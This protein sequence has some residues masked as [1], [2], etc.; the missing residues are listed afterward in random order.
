MS[1]SAQHQFSIVPEVTYGTTPANPVFKKK[2]ISG[3][4]LGLTKGRIESKAIRPDRQVDDVRHG[5]RLIGGEITTELQY[6]GFDDLIEAVFCGTWTLDVLVPGTVRRSFSMLRQFTDLTAAGTFPY[7]LAKGVELAS[8]GLS[9]SP[10]SFVDTTFGAIGRELIYSET[11]PAGTTYTNAASGRGFDAFSGSISVNEVPVANITALDINIDN[12]ME[13]RN[14]LFTDLTN[15]PK[16]GKTRV[17]GEI[18]LYFESSDL[19]IAF[20]GGVTKKLEVQL[21]SPEGND[22]YLYM[23]KLLGLGGQPDVSGEDDITIAFSFDALYDEE[24]EIG[25]QSA[26]RLTRVP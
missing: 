5:N 12:G 16:I 23:P 4:T 11:A 1:N 22:Y 13:P 26:I 3:T 21:T 6:G 7:H 17:S 15:R 20:N 2:R 19:L 25:S 10:E 8:M 14:V 9:L 24:E 18:T